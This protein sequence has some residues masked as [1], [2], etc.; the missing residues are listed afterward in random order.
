MDIEM[1]YPRRTF[2]S[3]RGEE[4]RKFKYNIYILHNFFVTSKILIKYILSF[5]YIFVNFS[6]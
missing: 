5:L 6:Y 1:P 2:L 3:K 4:T